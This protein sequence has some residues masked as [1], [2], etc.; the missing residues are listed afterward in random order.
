MESERSAP[1]A[2]ALAEAERVSAGARAELEL[3][4]G[5]LATWVDLDTPGGDL[6][7]LDS[8]ARLLAGVLDRYGVEPELVEAPSG[9]YVHGAVR[10]NG[11]ARVALVC[12]HDTVFP[13]G[14][15]AARPFRRDDSRCYGP[16][17][18][19]M[20]GG[21]AVAVHTARLLARGPR[22]FA[23]VEVVS[24]PD[25]ESRPAPPATV[26]RLVTMDAVLCLECGRPNGEVVSARKGASWLRIHATGKAAHAGEAPRAGRNVAQ[27]LAQEALRLA[28]LD[29]ARDGLSL[30]ITGLEAGEGLNTVPSSGVLTAD[31][32]ASTQDDL[33]WT[34]TRIREFPA[35]D[36]ITL[37][38]EDLGGPP[39][40]ERT[41]AVGRL[42]ET[43]IAIGA[44]LGGNFGEAVAGGVSDGSWTAARGIP[45]LDG[46]GPV[47]GADHS[48]DEYVETASF[49]ERCGVVAGLVAAV[50]AG[51]LGTPDAGLLGTLLPQK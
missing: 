21:L 27:A 13:A 34:T 8:F 26:D 9:F 4:L 48:P 12:H 49:A 28:A 22:P 45:T 7:A 6:D 32:R 36:G 19:D 15:A 46:L 18:A 31:I 39:P 41:P 47:G 1:P 50:D 5:D 51:L 25:E 3:V 11:S 40:F 37:R 44:A 14:T 38:Y 17:V 10:G 30:Q 2:I 42:A 29:G 16:G 20:K 33:D 35:Y 23:L 24:A 43:A